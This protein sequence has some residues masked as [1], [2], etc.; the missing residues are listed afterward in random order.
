MRKERLLT[1]KDQGYA[2]PFLLKQKLKEEVV[3][4]VLPHKV[5][6]IEYYSLSDG[7][8]RIFTE[9]MHYQDTASK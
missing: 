3:R 9:K 1:C 7:C 2:P 5:Q 8:R 6:V 4:F